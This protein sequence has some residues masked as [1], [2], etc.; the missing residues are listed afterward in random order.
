VRTRE[1]ALTAQ[2]PLTV[3][4]SCNLAALLKKVGHL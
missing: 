2:H 1:E 3:L 4:S